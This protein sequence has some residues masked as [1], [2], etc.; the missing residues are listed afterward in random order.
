MKNNYTNLNLLHSLA[1]LS[2]IAF[3]LWLALVESHICANN[4]GVTQFLYNLGFTGVM[5]FFVHTSL[6]TQPA[7]GPS[8]AASVATLEHSPAGGIAPSDQLAAGGPPNVQAQ[9]LEL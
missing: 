8:K 3:H 4:P 5:F 9:T 7:Q 1:V 6:V 2:V